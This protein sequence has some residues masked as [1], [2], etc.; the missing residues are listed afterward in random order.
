MK[1]EHCVLLLSALYSG[2]KL[3][4]GWCPWPETPWGNFCANGVSSPAC[5]RGT[6]AA[7]L[8]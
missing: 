4:I 1:E 8:S 2:G 6:A 7:K 3:S 5:R